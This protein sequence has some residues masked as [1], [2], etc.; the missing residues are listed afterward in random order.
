MSG[1]VEYH[2]LGELAD[3]VQ[4]QVSEKIAEFLGALPHTERSEPV[5]R[6]PSTAEQGHPQTVG[7]EVQRAAVRDRIEIRRFREEVYPEPRTLKVVHTRAL[8]EKFRVLFLLQRIYFQAV[9]GQ[10]QFVASGTEQFPGLS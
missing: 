4:F 6:L 2:R 10:H 9:L 1:G 7:R 5:S 3:A 8:D